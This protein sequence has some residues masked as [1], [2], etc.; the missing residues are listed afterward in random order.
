[1]AGN[2]RLGRPRK[3]R[4]QEL[5]HVGFKL[6]ADLF[7]DFS[8]LAIDLRMTKAELIQTAIK[9]FVDRHNQDAEAEAEAVAL[10]VAEA[11]ALG[12]GTEL[13]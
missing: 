12:L 7:R 4:D 6:N 10:A 3:V 13:N 11:V 9:E 5:K 2:K 8:K 1:M